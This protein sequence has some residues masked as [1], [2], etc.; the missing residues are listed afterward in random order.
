MINE[1]VYYETVIDFE[2]I[3]EDIRPGMTVDV[4]ILAFSKENVLVIPEDAI[5]EKN[6][7]N[8]VEV[9]IGDNFEEREIQTGLEGDD[10]MIEVVSGLKEGEKVKVE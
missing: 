4:D 7:K 10:G 3:P 8:T 6:G 5:S 9:M 2:E 1:V